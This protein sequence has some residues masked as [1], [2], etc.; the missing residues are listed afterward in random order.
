INESLAKLE[1]GSLTWGIGK[2]DL[3]LKRDFFVNNEFLVGYDPDSEADQTLLVG[4]V[5]NSSQ[6]PIA[7]LANYACH[8]TTFGPENQL[9]SPDFV[10]AMREIVFKQKKAPCIFLQ[11]ASG[12]LAPMEQYV[13]DPEIVDA[14]GRKLGYAILSVIEG[15]R[16]S[17]A[18]LTFTGLL[19]SGAPLAL[20]KRR[21]ANVS[22]GISSKKFEIE[23][24]FKNLPS[25]EL[26]RSEYEACQDRVLKDRLW[27][28]LT[29]R[30]AIENAKKP[31]IP[32]WVWQFGETILIAQPNEA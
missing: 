22:S 1:V 15:I 25:I 29:T 4:V 23:V 14:H 11:G 24:A 18:D 10:G 12:D 2:C 32:L 3:A 8:P 30:T 21:K 13:N 17:D 9:L 26:I 20:W 28:K 7:I 16:P 6:V 5:R 19:V 31:I 27:R